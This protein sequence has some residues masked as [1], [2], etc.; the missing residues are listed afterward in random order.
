MT[1]QMTARLIGNALREHAE[2]CTLALRVQPGA[3][4]SGFTGVYGEGS[5]SRLKISLQAPPIEGRANDA[6]IAFLATNFSISKTSVE[7][8]SGELSRSKIVLLK[9]VTRPRA[10][11]VLSVVLVQPESFL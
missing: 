7:I 11:A 2:G 4:K 5:E 9:G 3:K 1:V 6:V 8:L 10:E